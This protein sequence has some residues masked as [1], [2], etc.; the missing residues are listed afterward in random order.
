MEQPPVTDER[1]V[2]FLDDGLQ[3]Y[4]GRFVHQDAFDPHSHGFVEVVVVTGGSGVHLSPAGRRRL[5]IGDVV[6]LR[7][8][9]WHGYEDCAELDVYN[10]C[11][12]SELLPRDLAWMREDPLL[13]HLLWTGPRSA[14]RRGVLDFGLGQAALRECRGHLDALNAL[15]HAPVRLYRGDIVGRLSAFLGVLARAAHAQRQDGAQPDGRTHPA[16]VQAMR[17]LEE[18]PAHPWTVPQLADELHISPGYLARLFKEV[19]GLPPMAYLAQHRV[20]VATSLLRRTD[21]PVSRVARAVGW[22]DQNLF[23]RRFRA[24]AGLSAST[25]RKRFADGGAAVTDP[26]A[27]HGGLNVSR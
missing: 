18:R 9:L 8:G 14:R 19:T 17:L 24:H 3:V 4:A 27:D 10:C 11:F 23:A 2:L 15:R 6:L 12:S 7:P 16:V 5:G 1:G 20:E 25:Y 13:G 22:P 21:W 26:A